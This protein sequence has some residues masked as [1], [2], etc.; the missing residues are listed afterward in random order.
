MEFNCSFDFSYECGVS[1]VCMS[2]ISGD[3]DVTVI[4]LHPTADLRVRLIF[5]FSVDKSRKRM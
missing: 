5:L 3:G 4:L 1:S 2:H